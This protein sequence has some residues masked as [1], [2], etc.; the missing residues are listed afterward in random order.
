MMH[1]SRKP[2]TENEWATVHTT[3][4]WVQILLLLIMSVR[5]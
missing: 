2:I 5:Q 1:Q 3:I 4:R